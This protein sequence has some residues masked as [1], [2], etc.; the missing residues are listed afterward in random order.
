MRKPIKG[1]EGLYEI[2]DKGEVITLARELPTPTTKYISKEKISFGYKNNK[3]YL[4]FDFRRRGGKC[5]PVHRLVA[6]AFIPNPNNY[7]QINHKDGNKQNNCVDNLEWCNNSINQI[8]AFKNKLQQGGFKHPNSKLTYNQVVYI[9]RNYKK[10]V[11]GYGMKKLA[12]KFN[13]SYATIQQIIYG[14]SYKT[15]V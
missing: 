6:E 9:K 4:V 13:V 15:I 11:R 5:I 3:G 14:K 8:H 2:S 12:K 7:P 10:G 1:F